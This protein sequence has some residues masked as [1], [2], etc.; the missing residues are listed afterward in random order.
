MIRILAL[1]CV[2]AL[3]VIF[4][5]GLKFA[6]STAFR[7][8]IARNSSAE[9]RVPRTWNSLADEK[10][11]AAFTPCFTV[12]CRKIRSS[13]EIRVQPAFIGQE[14]AWLLRTQQTMK[15][16]TTAE[17]TVTPL[18]SFK[19]I[20]SQDQTASACIG[21]G[22]GLIGAFKGAS[23]DLEAFHATL[24]SARIPNH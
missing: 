21:F 7:D 12:F 4:W 17:P 11:I 13:M 22:T 3:S 24:Q 9:I 14:D 23:S 1:A 18:G 20:E 5:P 8:P 10:A 15:I 19:C 2:L 6:A 16:L